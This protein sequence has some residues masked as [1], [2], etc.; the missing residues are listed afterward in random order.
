VDNLLNG[1]SIALY[2]LP[3]SRFFSNAFRQHY[4]KLPE[5]FAKTYADDVEKFLRQTTADI[6]K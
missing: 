5:Q 3:A 4:R 6:L 1:R 2:G